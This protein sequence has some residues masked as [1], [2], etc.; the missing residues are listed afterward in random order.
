MDLVLEDFEVENLPRLYGKGW[1]AG[2]FPLSHTSLFVVFVRP[3][4]SPVTHL[5]RR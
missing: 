2:L 5:D 3:T 4:P 1:L